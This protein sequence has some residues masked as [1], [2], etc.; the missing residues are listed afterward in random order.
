MLI[1]REEWRLLPLHQLTA[2]HLV[3][4]PTFPTQHYVKLWMTVAS[5]GESPSLDPSGCPFR[6]G[7][8]LSWGAVS[9]RVGF[10]DQATSSSSSLCLSTGIHCSYST[11]VLAFASVIRSAVSGYSWGLLGVPERAEFLES[12]FLVPPDGCLASC[13]GSRIAQ[14]CPFEVPAKDV[15]N[16][17]ENEQ[18][19][20]T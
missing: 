6:V 7:T 14:E 15:S 17:G 13:I 19:A 10:P 18:R 5:P 12:D 16:A 9:L 20:L 8:A 1:G 4:Q 2:Q 11:L 3:S